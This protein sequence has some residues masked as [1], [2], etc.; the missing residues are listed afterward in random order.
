MEKLAEIMG[1]R[2]AEFEDAKNMYCQ[3]LDV[4]ENGDR[5]LDFTTDATTATTIR[6]IAQIASN[7]FDGIEAEESVLEGLLGIT[8]G[9][10]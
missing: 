7:A 4:I 6:I 10:E 1:K 3:I 2:L 9:E 8:E 5:A